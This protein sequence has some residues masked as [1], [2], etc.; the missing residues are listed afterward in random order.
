M[1]KKRHSVLEIL[2]SCKSAPIKRLN[3]TAKKIASSK[4]TQ[5]EK[6]ITDVSRNRCTIR[7]TKYNDG[8]ATKKIISRSSLKKEERKIRKR[9]GVKESSVPFLFLPYKSLFYLSPSSLSNT[10]IYLLLFSLF[11]FLYIYNYYNQSRFFFSTWFSFSTPRHSY[12]AKADT[13]LMEKY[14][15]HDCGSEKI[16]RKAMKWN[17][18][19]CVFT[20]KCRVRHSSGKSFL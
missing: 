7:K 2:R 9:S 10:H 15:R 1:K 11:S 6:N 19:K 14:D 17:W 3:V 8:F 20:L 4:D 16:M 5:S 12:P 13:C 18:K